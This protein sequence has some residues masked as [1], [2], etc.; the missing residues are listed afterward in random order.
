MI[1]MATIINDNTVIS[2][3]KKKNNFCKNNENAVNE[4]FSEIISDLYTRYGVDKVFVTPYNI[5]VE[6]GTDVTLTDITDFVKFHFYGDY[7]D[8][9][10]HICKVTMIR[11]ENSNVFN[12]ERKK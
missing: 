5:S 6:L 8:M 2:S 1:S 4:I 3:I 11:M 9:Y 7:I 10:K 12:I